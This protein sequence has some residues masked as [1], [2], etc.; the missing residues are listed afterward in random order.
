VLRRRQSTPRAFKEAHLLDNEGFAVLWRNAQRTRNELLGPW[1]S[2]RLS[3]RLSRIRMLLSG[4]ALNK[5]NPK[6]VEQGELR[7]AYTRTALARL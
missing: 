4:F 3:Q 2:Q 7:H 5:E 1:L 6:A